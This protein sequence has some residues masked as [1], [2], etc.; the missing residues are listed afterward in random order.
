[1][2][3]FKILEKKFLAYLVSSIVPFLTFSIFFAD[4]ICSILSIFFIVYLVKYNSIFF[5]KNLIFIGTIFFYFLCLFSSFFSEEILFSLKSSLPLIRIIIFIFLISYLIENNKYFLN[6]F[7]NFLKYTFLIL[8]FYGLA[9]YFYEYSKLLTN[10]AIDTSYIRLTLPF[11]DEEKLG[12]FLVRLNGLLIAIY[13]LKKNPNKSENIFLF[14]LTLFTSF[15]ILLSGE[16]SSLFFLILFLLICFISL[17]I[18]FKFKISVFFVF[19][20]SFFLILSQNSNLSNRMLFDKN[21]DLN[22]SSNKKELVIFTSQHTA[23]YISGF[24]MFKDKPFIGQGPRMFRVL[25]KKEGYNTTINDKKSCSSHPH[26]T[27]IQ[28]LAEIGIFGTILFSLI[29]F[30]IIFVLI[31]HV[32]SKI[33]L[34]KNILSNYQIIICTSVLIVVWPFS[35]SGNFFNNWMLIIYAL[36]IGFYFNEFFR[37]NFYNKN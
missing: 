29:F 18:R 28:L 30:H 11:S 13:L 33:F 6:V 32:V 5:Y 19:L 10:N 4:L 20:A 14:F 23:H 25:C 1:M 24:Q 35:P 12:S 16:R 2:L 36:P 37:Y 34:K 21:N 26:N 8:I 27:Y 31:K 9:Q 22:L 7:F 3:S 15:V 17:N